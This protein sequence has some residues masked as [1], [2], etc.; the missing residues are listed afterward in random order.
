M[1]G[2][3]DWE[4][5]VLSKIGV[6]SIHLDI[7]YRISRDLV[8][9]GLSFASDKTLPPIATPDRIAFLDTETASLLQSKAR[10]INI[11]QSLG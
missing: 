7:Q 4:N 9:I 8:N 3:N 5:E 10:P 11:H 2:G 1:T 6:D